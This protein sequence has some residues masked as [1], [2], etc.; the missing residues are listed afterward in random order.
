MPRTLA[1]VEAMTSR[2]QL[3]AFCKHQASPRCHRV[4]PKCTAVAE[5]RLGVCISA[6][7]GGTRVHNRGGS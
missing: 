6:E 4:L 1:E 3:Q 7:C 5:N 2:R